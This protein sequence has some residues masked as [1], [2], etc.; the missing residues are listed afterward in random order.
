MDQKPSKFEKAATC[1]QMHS[2]MSNRYPKFRGL[3]IPVGNYL[4]K[5]SKITLTM[6]DKCFSKG[7]KSLAPT[8]PL[9]HQYWGNNGSVFGGVSRCENFISLRVSKVPFKKSTYEHP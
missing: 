1:T 2:S 7:A 5:V 8:L 3:T 4:F 6:D 9:G